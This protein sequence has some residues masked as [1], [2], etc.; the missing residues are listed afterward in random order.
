LNAFN[1]FHR[2]KKHLLDQQKPG[3]LTKGKK[4]HIA[5]VNLMLSLDRWKQNEKKRALEKLQGRKPGKDNKTRGILL[6]VLG[7][8]LILNRIRRPF[9]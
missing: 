5:I 9:R 3:K 8:K 4:K 6:S 1:A 7:D 2:L